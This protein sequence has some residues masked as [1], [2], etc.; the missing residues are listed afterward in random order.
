MI[1]VTAM[2]VAWQLQQLLQ[3]KVNPRKS[4]RRFLLFFAINFIGVFFIIVITGFII[5]HF[6]EFFFTP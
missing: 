6:K 5:I 1:I 4:L 2:Y 3:V